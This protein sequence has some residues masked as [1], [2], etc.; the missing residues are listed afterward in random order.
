MTVVGETFAKRAAEAMRARAVAKQHNLS[1][2]SGFNRPEFIGNLRAARNRINS[3]SHWLFSPDAR[4]ASYVSRRA[5]KTA[6]GAALLLATDGL[7]ALASDYGVYDAD[8]LVAAAL[9]KG[10]AAMGEELRAIE[11]GD[12]GGDKFPQIQNER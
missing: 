2:A 1:P 11:A 5:I 10:L 6:P 7:L 4:A 12:S 3:G 9:S 8:G